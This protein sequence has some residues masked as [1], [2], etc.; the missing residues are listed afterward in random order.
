MRNAI[1]WNHLKG[2]QHFSISES[3]VREFVVK[4]GK[5][6]VTENQ[7]IFIF[8]LQLCL[9][10]ILLVLARSCCF[11]KYLNQLLFAALTQTI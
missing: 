9:I 1:E 8:D 3:N 5:M 10:R 11:Q 4:T 6:Q 2:K 7:R